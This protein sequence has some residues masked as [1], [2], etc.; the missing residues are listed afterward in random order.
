[1]KNEN[2][3]PDH[4]SQRSKRESDKHQPTEDAE[5]IKQLP[6]VFPVDH[7]GMDRAFVHLA[8][9]RVGDP[10]ARYD[11]PDRRERDKNN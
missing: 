10:A 8:T 5:S 11:R 9:M 7:A 2:D 4:E 1:M 6:V 3:Q